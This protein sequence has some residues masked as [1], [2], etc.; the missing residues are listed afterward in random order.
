MNVRSWARDDLGEALVLGQEAV[1]RVDR[2]AAGDERGGDD[3]RAPRGTSGARRPGRCRSPRR[4]AGPAS[5][6]AVG[7]AVG[8]D[9]LDAERP[10]GAQDPQRDLAAVGDEDLAEHAS[11]LRGAARTAN[12]MTISSWPYSTASP[13]S[14]RLAPTTPSAGATTSWGT[15]SM[16][17]APSR[18]PARTR[19]P[20]AR[21]R[22][23]AGRCR[24]PASVAT[25][26]PSSR[27]APSRAVATVAAVAAVAAARPRPSRPGPT[28]VRPVL[29]VRPSVPARRGPR[30]ARSRSPGRRSRAGARRAPSAGRR[31]RTRQSPSRTSS[32]P[33]PVA[34]SLAIER[35]QELVG[36]GGRWRRGRPTA[37]RRSAP[38]GRHRGWIRFGH[39]ARPPRGPAA[40]RATRTATAAPTARRPGSSRSRRRS[41]SP[42]PA[43]GVDP[44]RRRPQCRT[45][46]PG[47][48]GSAL[49]RARRA[50]AP[51]SAAEPVDDDRLA[52]AARSRP[53][54]RGRPRRARAR[55]R[56]RRPSACWSAAVIRIAS[57]AV[58]ASSAVRHRIDGAALGRDDRVDRV[59]EGDDDV[60]DG[61]RERAARAALAGDDRH[62]RRPQPAHQ[63]DRAGDRLGDAA[64]LGF[65]P[66]MRAG[67]V[68]EGDDRQPEPLGELHDPHR[69]AVALGVGHPEVAPDV[70]VGVGAL[71]LADDDDPPAVEPGE[72]RRPSPGRRRTAG[73]RGA[74]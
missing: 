19:V 46:A 72:A 26:R 34:P 41:P 5:D 70:L 7:L 66:G 29:A 37:P 52:A 27:A 22:A 33:R 42:R 32:S 67:H 69:L 21:V 38:G 50:A 51:S 20:G 1:A 35:R 40:R 56:R 45:R 2:V 14:T 62:D 30:P 17:T 49:R 43:G 9:G 3:R 39:C 55:R 61:D 68:D 74:R 57:A 6:V 23:A 4:R 15:P 31:R 28:G 13:A 65:G 48:A 53:G 12:S 25:I 11:G 54:R 24:R 18:S 47:S 64:L 59:L 16:S 10:A 73:R 44:R 36:S 60:A 8:D 58:G 63:P 71:L